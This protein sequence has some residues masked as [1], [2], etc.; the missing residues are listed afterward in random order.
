MIL[1]HNNYNELRVIS[2]GGIER[3]F[4]IQPPAAVTRGPERYEISWK[5]VELVS[6]HGL[7]VISRSEIVS[8][9]PCLQRGKFTMPY[10]YIL[11]CSDFTF[12]TGSTKDLKRRLFEHES[13]QGAVYTRERLPVTLVYQ[14]YFKSIKQAFERE[15]QIKSWNQKKKT[16]LISGKFD[17]LK[18][19]AKKRFKK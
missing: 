8:R 9:R 15:H 13:D 16:A 6:A 19:L 3:G 12:Y 2:R 18:P 14:E 1:M 7:R 17:N 4:S 5:G 10:V 11:K